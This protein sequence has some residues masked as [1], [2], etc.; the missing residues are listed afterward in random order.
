MGRGESD[1][2]DLFRSEL[3]D[4]IERSDKRRARFEPAASVYEQEQMT[5]DAFVSAAR[6][7]EARLS[8]LDPVSDRDEIVRLASSLAAGAF[9]LFEPD[10]DG[11]ITLRSFG[12]AYQTIDR[13]AQQLAFFAEIINYS[14]S[15]DAA[16][17]SRLLNLIH[18]EADRIEK[19]AIRGEI[20]RQLNFLEERLGGRENV[21]KLGRVS[22]A[23][24]EKWRQ[25]KTRPAHKLSLDRAV[26][27][28]FE[29]ERDLCWSP[30]EISEWMLAPNNNLLNPLS[31][32]DHVLSPRSSATTL[33]RDILEAAKS[34][35]RVRA[36]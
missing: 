17:L 36:L 1:P 13:Q 25:G 18:K 23:T 32:L 20:C 35:K 19:Q 3:F 11:E 12:R 10:E 34:E 31:P 16:S 5:E 6:E 24:A 27:T 29:I 4:Q 7:V 21:A 28:L 33:W 8:G 2:E 15:S 9:P 14:I 30:E 22:L 26:N